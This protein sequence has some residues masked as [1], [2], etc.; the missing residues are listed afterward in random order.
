M[1]KEQVLQVLKREKPFLSENF[2]VKRIGLFGSYATGTHTANSDI[3]LL[4]DMPSK[5]DLYYDLKEFL[6][7]KFNKEID[8]GYESSIRHFIKKKIADEIIYV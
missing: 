1:T 8:L 5:F 3:D 7:K 6:Q 2:G 4:V